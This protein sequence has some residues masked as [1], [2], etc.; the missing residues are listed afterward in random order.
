MA[1]SHVIVG[2]DGSGVSLRAVEWAAREAALRDRPLR[3]VSVPALPPRMS[4]YQHSG[5]PAVADIVHERAEEAVAGAAARAAAVEPG[6]AVS[7]AVLPWAPSDV[8][9]QT[10]DGAAMLVV[11]SRG[12]G[13]FA[14]LLLGSVGRDVAFTADCPVVVVRE[15]AMAGHRQVVIGVHDGPQA[16]A[17]GFAFEEAQRRL[18]RL[19]VVYGWQIFLPGLRPGRGGDGGSDAQRGTPEAAKWL[20]GLIA[21]WRQKYPAVDV[22]EDS[23]HASPSRVLVGASARADLVVLGR[24]GGGPDSGNAGSGA[25]AHA[26]LN[27]AHCPVAIIPEPA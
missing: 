20:A 3:I 13:G 24:D 14:A 17:L 15:E 19:Q 9:A 18:A 11:G 8:L 7:T 1:D 10:A 16:S 12:G 23:V 2:T 22:T 27:H 4:W 25:L 6:V 5:P 26:M 21:P